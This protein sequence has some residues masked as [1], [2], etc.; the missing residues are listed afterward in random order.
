MAGTPSAP[1]LISRL[2]FPLR[3]PGYHKDEL[4]KFLADLAESR[5]NVLD[6]EE[7]AEVRAEYL[8]GLALPP[9]RPAILIVIFVSLIAGG[10]IS[11]FTGSPGF[12]IFFIALGLVPWWGQERKWRDKHNLSLAERLDI[13]DALFAASLISSDEAA[14][15]R[16][17]IADRFKPDV[18]PPHRKIAELMST[19]ATDDKGRPAQRGLIFGLLVGCIPAAIGL[20]VLTAGQLSFKSASTQYLLVTRE[21]DPVTYWIIVWAC[22]AAAILIWSKTWSDFSFLAQWHGKTGTHLLVPVP[23]IPPPVAPSRFDKICH[24][25]FY[26]ALIN[27]FLFAIGC[28]LLRGDAIN[29]KVENGRYFLRQGR[30]YKEVPR[31]VFLYSKFHLYSVIVTHV[32]AMALG[33]YADRVR[34]RRSR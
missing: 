22:T 25:I 27:F 10:I 13:V 9:K 6:E 32:S 15:L 8:N 3:P 17:G 1:T 11:I 33:F 4:F 19:R 2:I 34:K 26:A 23:A 31:A 21:S 28:L 18:R 5:G 24:G 20:F 12:G 14:A 30:E 7:Y 16:K 29:G